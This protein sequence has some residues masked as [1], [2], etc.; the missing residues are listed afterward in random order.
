MQNT[1]KVEVRLW[2]FRVSPLH[3]CQGQVHC[4]KPPLQLPRRLLQ[5]QLGACGGQ[6]E[7]CLPWLLS[8]EVPPWPALQPAP[9]TLDDVR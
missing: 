4:L 2:M 8:S 1:V 3:R 9:P 6:P 5:Q 7:A